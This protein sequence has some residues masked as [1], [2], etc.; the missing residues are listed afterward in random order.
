MSRRT[1][2]RKPPSAGSCF[3]VFL[4]ILFRNKNPNVIEYVLRFNK[5]ERSLFGRKIVFNGSQKSKTGLLNAFVTNP[6]K[7][8]KRKSGQE[9]RDGN[10]RVGA[11]LAWW[12]LVAWTAHLSQS[13]N[14]LTA[15]GGVMMMDQGRSVNGQLF[16]Q[17]SDGGGDGCCDDGRTGDLRWNDQGW[18]ITTSPPPATKR[19]IA[20]GD[21]LSA[22][23]GHRDCKRPS[24][25]RQR[26]FGP[27]PWWQQGGRI[28]Y[29]PGLIGPKTPAHNKRLAQVW[30]GKKPR[31]SLKYQKVTSAVHATGFC[32]S[33]GTT[34][35][36]PGSNCQ[37]RHGRW[38]GT[39]GEKQVIWWQ[40]LAPL[41][42]IFAH[43]QTCSLWAH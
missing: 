11:A 1:C 20:D 22:V 2:P 25:A 38:N 33:A 5:V 12:V 9:R 43:W 37:Y 30:A 29:G 31:T 10:A 7:Q 6:S 19:A 3:G 40:R 14:L 34:S 8:N 32:S 4:G 24:K 36:I 15:P 26:C 41:V 21:G 16:D 18:W 27:G 42:V 23:A 17:P 35:W 13:C 39:G 28:T